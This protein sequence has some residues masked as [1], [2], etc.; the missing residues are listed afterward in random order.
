LLAILFA[1][2]FGARRCYPVLNALVGR[3]LRRAME[4]SGGN[5][6]KQTTMTAAAV[7]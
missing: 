5:A 3:T 4:H 7:A 2:D 1:R 6:M